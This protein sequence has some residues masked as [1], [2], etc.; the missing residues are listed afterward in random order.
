MQNQNITVV[1]NSFTNYRSEIKH[2]GDHPSASTLMKHIR[3]A[4]AKGCKSDTQIWGPFSRLKV[5]K[6]WKGEYK[7]ISID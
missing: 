7:V 6:E 5:T 2:A 3:R 4:K 1:S